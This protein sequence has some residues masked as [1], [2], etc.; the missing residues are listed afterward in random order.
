MIIDC[1]AARTGLL[2]RFGHLANVAVIVVHPHQCDVLGHLQTCIIS[3][4]HL[5]VGNEYLRDGSRVANA[6]GKELALIGNDVG[7]GGYSFGR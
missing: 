6:I 1:I 5:L 3:V 4:E 2:G 7:Q